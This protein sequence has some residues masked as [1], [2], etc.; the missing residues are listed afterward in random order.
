M[1][2]TSFIKELVGV[3]ET[4]LRLDNEGSKYTSDANL[5][6]RL[7]ATGNLSETTRILSE[8]ICRCIIVDSYP[9]RDNLNIYLCDAN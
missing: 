7:T 5:K 8:I 9:M 4:I 1:K 3:E 6:E 2:R